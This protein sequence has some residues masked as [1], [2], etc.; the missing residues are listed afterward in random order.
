[1]YTFIH[2]KHKRYFYVDKRIPIAT[3]VYLFYKLTL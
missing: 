2:T 3:L 1:M